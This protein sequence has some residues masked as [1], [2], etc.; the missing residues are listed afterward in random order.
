MGRCFFATIFPSGGNITHTPTYG[1][2]IALGIM[3]AAE[4][5]SVSTEQI[6]LATGYRDTLTSSG[7][8]LTFSAGNPTIGYR[9]RPDPEQR[10]A[11]K[12]V[13]ETDAGLVVEGKIAMLTSPA[14]AED[15][16][17]GSF[18][19]SQHAGQLRDVHRSRSMRQAS[20]SS[21]AR[22]PRATRTRSS[23]RC[24]TATTSSTVSCGWTRSWCPGSASSTWTRPRRRWPRGCSGI[25]CTA[26]WPRPSSRWVWRWPAHTRWA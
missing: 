26:G 5:K 16:Y 18:S 19:A 23:P 1:Y 15:V 11:L 14:Y 12:L 22:S 21:V 10:A 24:R 7:R 3:Y 13:R 2:L 6:A 9:L 4:V 20:R 8:F 17:I 25:S